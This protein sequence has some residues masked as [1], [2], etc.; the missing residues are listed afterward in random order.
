MS[1]LSKEFSESFLTYTW[2]LAI[3]QSILQCNGME[4][5]SNFVYTSMVCSF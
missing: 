5:N 3:I 2:C 4:Q 1:N